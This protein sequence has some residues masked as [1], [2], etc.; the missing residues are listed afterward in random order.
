MPGELTR[1]FSDLHYGDRASRVRTLA[2]L[3]P[4]LDGIDHLV[5]NG[6]TMD[7]RP[8]PVPA[9]TAQC[10]AEVLA[11]FPA[12][13]P[14]TTFLTGNHDADL[15]PHH[16][17]DLA[18]GRLFV[19]H[20]DIFYHDIVPWSQDAPA[21]RPQIAAGLAALPAHERDQL[22][23]RFA[24]WRRVAAAIPQRHQSESRGFRYLQ[25]FARDTVWPPARVWRIL[26]TWRGEGATAAAFARTHRP[27]LLYT[28]PSPRA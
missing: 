8:S 13:T 18:G 21:I 6:D 28:S 22:A 20:G 27:C 5:L 7:T 15:T 10:R 16:S 25:H 3:R 2:Q 9:H 19:T 11:F 23:A 14:R 12:Q 24:V 17:L 26:R 1:I 4:L